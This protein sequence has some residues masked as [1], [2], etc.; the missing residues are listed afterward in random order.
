MKI[1]I[2]KKDT[3]CRVENFYEGILAIYLYIWIFN[4][5]YAL[6]EYIAIFRNFDAIAEV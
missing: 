2:Q 1:F 6:D 4:L 3:G 5:E